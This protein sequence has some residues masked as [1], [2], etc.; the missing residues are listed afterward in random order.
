[1]SEM[2]YDVLHDQDNHRFTVTHEGLTAELNYRLAGDEMIITHIGVPRQLEGRGIGSLLAKTGL[3][4][5]RQEEMGVVPICSFARRYI[6][7]N[8]EYEPLIRKSW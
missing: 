8:P 7:R 3:D 2:H 4:Y 6:D 1:M 5:A